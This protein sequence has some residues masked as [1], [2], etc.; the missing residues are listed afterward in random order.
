MQ[1]YHGR[2]PCLSEKSAEKLI[3]LVSDSKKDK[4]TGGLRCGTTDCSKESSE[5]HIKIRNQKSALKLNYNK[6]SIT[7]SSFNAALS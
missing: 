3:L 6:K 5:F 4:L 1:Q 2:L 7:L